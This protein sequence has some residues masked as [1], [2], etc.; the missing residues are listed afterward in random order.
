MAAKRPVETITGN[1]EE[2]AD[3]CSISV[4]LELTGEIVDDLVGECGEIEFIGLIAIGDSEVERPGTARLDACVV[5]CGR[6]RILVVVKEIVKLYSPSVSLNSV[7]TIWRR[8]IDYRG[9]E[10]CDQGCEVVVFDE[11]VEINK[12]RVECELKF[13]LMSL[14]SV[15]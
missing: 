1:Q 4:L 2:V 3:M 5:E 9:V 11:N 10:I 12:G 6:L 15:E 13:L 14:E 8:I 7:K